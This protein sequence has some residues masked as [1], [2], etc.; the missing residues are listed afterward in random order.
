MLNRCVNVMAFFI[1]ATAGFT[2]VVKS[3]EPS[4][5]EATSLPDVCQTNWKFDFGPGKVESGYIQILPT[6]VYSEEL[7][8]GFEPGAAVEAIDRG[9]EDEIRGDFCTSNQPFYFSIKLPEGNYKITITLGDK[10]EESNTTI[11]AEL[12]RLMLEKVRTK[13]GEFETRT[14]VVN[15]RTPNISTDGQVRLKDREKTTEFAAWDDKLTLEFNGVRPCVC[16]MEITKAND[17]PTIYLLGDSTVCDQPLEPWNSWGQML[18]RFFKPSV[19]IANHAES[20]ESIRSSIGARRIDKIMSIIKQGD[21]L[22]IQFGHN[23][24]K[25]HSPNALETYKSNFKK[26]VADTRAKG[27]TPV[28]VTSMERKTGV[29]SDTLGDY[30]ETVRQ[31]AKEDNVALIDLHTMSKIFYKALGENIDKAF[32]DGTHHNNYGSYEL[33][34]CVVEG[35]KQNKLDIAKYIVDDFKGFDPNNP[36]PVDSFIMP[37]SPAR[38]TEKPDGN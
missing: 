31:V 15:I 14:I 29:D 1:V 34:K 18:T 24:M 5:V 35:I 16:A 26:L 2:S 22:F 32:Q 6:T 30:P 38:T 28:L 27:A 3:T 37:A 7:G 11:K 10:N 9:G 23:D 8:Y 19:A 21:Y 33:A 12:R 17:I 4:K 13:P 20:G 36:D 25:D